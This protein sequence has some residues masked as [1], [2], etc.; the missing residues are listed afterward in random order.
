[1]V[2]G[3]HPAHWCDSDRRSAESQGSLHCVSPFV[4]QS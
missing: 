2:I 4:A 3:S 1:V